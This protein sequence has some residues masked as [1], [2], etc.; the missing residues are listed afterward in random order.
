MEV[1]VVEIL[2]QGAVEIVRARVAGKDDHAATGPPVLGVV[3]IGEDLHLHDAFH[4][5]Y[6]DYRPVGTGVAHAV[7]QYLV[8]LVLAAVDRN[9]GGTAAVER[10]QIA[11]ASDLGHTRR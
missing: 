3:G 9:P 2:E 8:L 1:V 7:E 6:A 5:G 11:P 4:G 10:T